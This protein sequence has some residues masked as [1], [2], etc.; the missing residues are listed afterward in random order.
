MSVC[1]QG[2]GVPVSE[3]ISMY[4]CVSVSVHL[5]LSSAT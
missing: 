2:E 1:I 5:S 4:L 3:A